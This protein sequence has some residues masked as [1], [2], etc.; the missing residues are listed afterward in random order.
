M[1]TYADNNFVWSRSNDLTVEDNLHTFI[2]VA[3]GLDGKV[4]HVFGTYITFF[5]LLTAGHELVDASRDGKFYIN[6][7]KDGQV[8]ET[9]EAPEM[10]WALL[11]SEPDVIELVRDARVRPSFVNNGIVYY[12]KEDWSY[13]LIDGQYTFE[14]PIGWSLP[15]DAR[16]TSE[17]FYAKQVAILDRLKESYKKLYYQH[18]EFIKSLED[19]KT[20]DEQ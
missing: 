7:I 20:P 19:L 11:L 9:L 17:E 1:I 13:T 3:L 4:H 6:F 15:R 16:E 12:V 10:V 14:P 8:V 18:P 5:E 2:S